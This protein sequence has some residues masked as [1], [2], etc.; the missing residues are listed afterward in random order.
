MGEQNPDFPGG[1][2]GVTK[3]PEVGVHIRARI[4]QYN[5]LPSNE[6][7]PGTVK[8]KGAA[9]IGLDYPGFQRSPPQRRSATN[10]SA[11][12]SATRVMAS[13]SSGMKAPGSMESRSMTP[14]MSSPARIRITSSEDIDGLSWM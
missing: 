4:D 3:G 1:F 9:V 10:C 8:G 6:E 2:Q 5:L 13:S 12:L 14:K 7:G 11:N